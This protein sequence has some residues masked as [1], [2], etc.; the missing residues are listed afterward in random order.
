ML[1]GWFVLKRL[2]TSD[3]VLRAQ[4][5]CTETKQEPR[6]GVWGGGRGVSMG[7]AESINLVVYRSS[8]LSMVTTWTTD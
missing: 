2:I 4:E 8:L 6:L 3:N 7:T 5:T 1:S